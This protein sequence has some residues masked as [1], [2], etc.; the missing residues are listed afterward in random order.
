MKGAVARDESKALIDVE[1]IAEALTTMSEV[2]KQ[3]L[4]GVIAGI[5]LARSAQPKAS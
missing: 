3:K 5:T 1:G 4:I 2:D